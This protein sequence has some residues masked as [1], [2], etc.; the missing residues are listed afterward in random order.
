MSAV[1]LLLIPLCPISPFGHPD[2]PVFG[3]IAQM[4]KSLCISPNIAWTANLGDLDPCLELRP[5]K[6]D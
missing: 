2:R 4:T 5:L 3:N 1:R 6:E